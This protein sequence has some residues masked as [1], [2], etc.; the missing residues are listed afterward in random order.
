ML[1]GC[2]CLLSCQDEYED[3]VVQQS[4]SSQIQVSVEGVTS[5]AWLAEAIGTMS[6][7][8]DG[9]KPFV[10]LV[11]HQGRQYVHLELPAA[12]G[13]A[14]GSA[15]YSDIGAKLSDTDPLYKDVLAANDFNILWWEGMRSAAATRATQPVFG[16]VVTLYTPLGSL[17]PYA[18]DEIEEY[19]SD[20]RANANKYALDRSTDAVIER[21]ASLKYNCYAYAWHMTEGGSQVWLGVDNGYTNPAEIYWRDGSYY[22]TTA[23]NADKVMY[24]AGNHAAI[25]TNTPGWVIS[26]WGSGPL[27]RHRLINGPY[28]ATEFKYY[29]KAKYY[30]GQS[31]SDDRGSSSI[32]ASNGYAGT[33]LRAYT[34]GTKT[35]TSYQ[36]SAQFNGSCDRWY[37]WPS[38]ASADISVCFNSMS[39]GGTMRV[40][41]TMYNGNWK[42]GD[43]Y[44]YLTVIPGPSYNS[45]AAEVETAA[46]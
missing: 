37:I 33:T 23:A 22:E 16:N 15:V 9:A 32:Y 28:Y 21:D 7:Q 41:C 43:R 44:Y 25:T 1:I 13:S 46:M 39:S 45:V 10:A 19:T 42:I 3:N 4:I 38:G 36:W 26:K 29:K 17:V 11:N 2:T 5:P 18:K 8:N 24:V 14:C 27:M 6:E 30:V 34:T 40:T 12:D 35:P 31:Y 20:E